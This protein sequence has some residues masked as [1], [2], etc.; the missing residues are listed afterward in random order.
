MI[1]LEYAVLQ[2]IAYQVLAHLAKDLESF[3]P[4]LWVREVFYGQRSQLS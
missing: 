4:L 2:A 1:L 3:W